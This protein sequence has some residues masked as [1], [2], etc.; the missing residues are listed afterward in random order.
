MALHWPKLTLAAFLCCKSHHSCVATVNSTLWFIK[1][2]CK[3]YMQYSSWQDSSYMQQYLFPNYAEV[4]AIS[5]LV[6]NHLAIDK[7]RN[8]ILKLRKFP[9]KRGTY[10][11]LNESIYYFKD[12]FG[13]KKFLLKNL[14]VVPTILALLRRLPYNNMHHLWNNALAWWQIN[15]H[16]TQKV[17]NFVQIIFCTQ[18]LNLSW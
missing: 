3:V 7:M 16:C 12:S 5:K 13:R 18:K 15:Y 17:P 9:K 1:S 10:P 8:A 6:R 4:Y 14:K 11:L 2:S